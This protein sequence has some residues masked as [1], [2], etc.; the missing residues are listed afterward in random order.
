MHHLLLRHHL[1]HRHPQGGGHAP[2]PLPCTGGYTG[3][4]WKDAPSWDFLATS[5][6]GVLVGESS[7]GGRC[8]HRRGEV[9]QDSRDKT[10]DKTAETRRQ[11]RQQRQH[12]RDKKLD[13]RVNHGEVQNA[14]QK[15]ILLFG[16]L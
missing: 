9:G 13:S 11:I 14:I 7:L 1:L 8:R 3:P 10:A 12:G 6:A 16:P 5:L 4:G 2:Q 15:I